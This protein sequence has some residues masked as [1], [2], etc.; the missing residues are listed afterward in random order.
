MK[1]YLPSNF[2]RIRLCMLYLVFDADALSFVCWDTFLFLL[3]DWN[4]VSLD[5]VVFLDFIKGYRCVYWN[6]YIFYFARRLFCVN[7]LM[8]WRTSFCCSI[9]IRLRRCLANFM[10]TRS[11]YS[12]A[13]W[14]RWSSLWLAEFRF[15]CFNW[16]W[17]T[18]RL[19]II[20]L[21]N[22]FQCS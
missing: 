5:Q 4:G 19:L 6:V 8:C 21:C 11:S 7:L 17:A 9:V 3:V 20:F 16:F 12:S 14:R 10:F 18:F 1:V 22:F 15:T 2:L 13:C